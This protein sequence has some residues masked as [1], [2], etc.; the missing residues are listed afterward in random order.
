[1]KRNWYKNQPPNLIEE[2]AHATDRVNYEICKKCNDR[3]M[4]QFTHERR[5]RQRQHPGLL[6]RG[7]KAAKDYTAF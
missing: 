7:G 3:G 2:I 4:N 6:G 5:V 1:M